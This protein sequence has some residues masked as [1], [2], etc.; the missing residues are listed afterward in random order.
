M[1]SAGSNNG[2][3]PRR[4]ERIGAL[5]EHGEDAGC[6]ELSAVNELAE[7][8]ELSET[9]LQ[10]LLDRIDASGID[11]ADDCGRDA[12]EQVRYDN[13]SLAATTTDALQLFMREVSRFELLTAE[14]EVELAKRIERGDGSAKELMINSNLRLVVSIARRYQ[15]REL[16]LLDL[17]QEG[18]LGLIRASEK[19]D[20]RRGYK[21]STY[22]TWWIRQAVERGIANGARTIRL[23]VYVIEREKQIARAQ[24]RLALRLGR[25]PTEEEIAA[26]VDMPPEQVLDLHGV[27]RTV[28]SLDKPVGDDEGTPFGALLCS[29]DAQPEEQVELSLREEVVRSAMSSLPDPQRTVLE[30]RFGMAGGEEPRTIDEVVRQL[31]ISRNKVRRLEADGLARLGRSREILSLHETV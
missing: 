15:G 13:D 1:R 10:N 23:P 25:P 26:E 31:G 2:A 21:F 30:L 7:A 19:F 28:T 17:I 18:I 24:R 11:L 3:G 12:P 8:L 14:Q 22:A 4:D 9:D 6:L 20:W 5:L 27:S 29:A 16:T